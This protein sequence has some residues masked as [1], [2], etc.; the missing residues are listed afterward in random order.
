M[1]PRQVVPL[2]KEFQPDLILLDLMM[3]YLDGY[4]VMEQLRL[5]IPSDT[6][7][8]ILV[9]T[10]DATSLAKQRALSMGARDFLTKPLN[11]V[12]VLLRI[13]NLLKT[14]A[15]HLQQQKQNQI[16]EEKVEQ[17]TAQIQRQLE[18]LSALHTINT[19]IA[20]SFDLSMTLN[21]ALEQIVAQLDVDAA[22]VLLLNPY[23][24]TLEYA[25]G[26][27][28][29]SKVIERSRVRLGEGPAGRAVLDRQAVHIPN[30]VTAIKD[31]V[32]AETLSGEGLI[33]YSGVP[34]IAKGEVKGVLEI[35]QRTP[36]EAGEWLEFP[37]NIGW[38]GCHCRG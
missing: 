13:K 34:L 18:R 5:V 33:S 6:Y 21:I 37:G 35:F 26:S 30:L 27:G 15:L 25:D 14:R 17:R 4:A 38:A 10:A 32:H 9:L 12:E 2:V 22:Q 29:R 3:P 28:F 7:L 36:H 1:D 23:S 19:T 16:L 11:Q 20:G 31:F 8:P 24:Q